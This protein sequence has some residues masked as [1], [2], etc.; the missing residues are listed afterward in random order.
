MDG[1][2]PGWPVYILMPMA[3]LPIHDRDHNH[4]FR[5]RAGETF[6]AVPVRPIPFHSLKLSRALLRL[7]QSDQLTSVALL[8]LDPSAPSPSRPGPAIK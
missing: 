6:T 2:G 4:G 1:T 3:L 8:P 5:G 7:T